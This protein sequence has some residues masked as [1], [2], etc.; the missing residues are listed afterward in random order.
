MK[1]ILLLAAAALL[2]IACNSTKTYTVT[3]DIKGLTGNVNLI[4]SNEKVLADTETKDGT[5]TLSV[6]SETP[7]IATLQNGKKGLALVFLEKGGK[8]TVT[9]DIA[10]RKSIKVEGTPA[11]DAYNAYQAEFSKI[12]AMLDGEVT[13]AQR[14]QIYNQI[15]KL[16]D[17]NY[18]QNKTNIWGAYIL[19]S[20]KAYELDADGILAAVELLPEDLQKMPEVQSASELATA[21]KK[22]AVGQPYIDIT[23]PN[24]DST[25]VALSSLVGEGKLVLLDFWASWCGP[26]MGEAKYLTDAYAAY[27]DKGFEIYGVS[28]DSDRD[29]W[30]KAIADKGFVWTNVSVLEGWTNDAAKEYSVRSIPSNF[31]IDSKGIIVARNLR[32]KALEEKLAELLK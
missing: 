9:G 32:G 3:G 28:L 11:N 21:M 22:T 12:T 30:L 2:A 10:D 8:I 14:E 15:D 5:F 13:S 16:V 17:D 1:K 4:D 31:L 20:Q 26:C 18:E 6:K 29:S 7:V 27:H 23:L 25:K 19:V 24:A